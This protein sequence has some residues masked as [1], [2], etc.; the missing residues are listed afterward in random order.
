MGYGA[1]IIHSDTSESMNNLKLSHSE[2]D[3]VIILLAEEKNT[4]PLLDRAGQTIYG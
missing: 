4:L 2:K 1:I 3:R